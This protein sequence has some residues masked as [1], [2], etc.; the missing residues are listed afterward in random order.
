MSRI[1]HLFLQL[2]LKAKVLILFASSASV[3]VTGTGAYFVAQSL[4]T[5][6]EHEQ[7][8]TEEVNTNEALDVPS[9]PVAIEDNKTEEVVAEV[10]VEQPATQPTYIPPIQQQPTPT[11][12]P[13]PTPEPEPPTG[14]EPESIFGG[15]FT[16]SNYQFSFSY[17]PSMGTASS[18]YDPNAM[19]K[20]ETITFSSRAGSVSV[21]PMP[22][23]IETP[24]PIEEYS[25]NAASGQTFNVR[26]NNRNGIIFYE[27]SYGIWDQGSV[28]IVLS[29][30]PSVEYAKAE[31]NYIITSMNIGAI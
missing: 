31:A 1:L 21:N 28:T 15:T 11:P 23:G 17:M 3:A 26:I 27:A 12:Q 25:L 10:P 18:T 16:S 9:Y 29:G 30:Y 14:E 19:T 24:P 22:F 20:P 6:N 5:N 7:V 8:I 13:A 2:S 4:T